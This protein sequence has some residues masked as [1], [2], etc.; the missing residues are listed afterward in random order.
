MQPT[1]PLDILRQKVPFFKTF[2][3]RKHVLVTRSS[4]SKDEEVL[5]SD[6]SKSF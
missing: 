2:L 4:D 5:I 6:F 3:Q 1:D